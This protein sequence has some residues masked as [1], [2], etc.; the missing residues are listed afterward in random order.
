MPI[1]GRMEGRREG[2]RVLGK[3][4]GSTSLSQHYKNLSIQFTFV[5]LVLM[6]AVGDPVP[7]ACLPFCITRG[8][9]PSLLLL[10]SLSTKALTS[11]DTGIARLEE[12]GVTADAGQ[13]GRCQ[14]EG[15]GGDEEGELQE[16]P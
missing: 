11:S 7:C 3:E 9:I 1:E 13:A 8:P 16:D 6:G 15:R 2:G 5:M 10:F 14:H 4:E 12:A